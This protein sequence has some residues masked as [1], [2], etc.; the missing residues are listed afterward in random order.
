MFMK[1]VRQVATVV[2]VLIVALVGV[3]LTAIFLTSGRS[4]DDLKALNDARTSVIQL[5]GGIGLVGGLLF[6]WRTY[7]LSRGSQR[8]ERF[9]KAVGQLGES[10]ES[11]RAGGVYG[12]AK[13][14]QED[15]TYWPIIENLLSA[16][17]RERAKPNEQRTADLMA[18]LA[19]L[20]ARPVSSPVRVLDLR[21]ICVPKADLTNGNFEN[22]WFD[23]ASLHEADFTDGN[24]RGARMPKVILTKAKLHSADLRESTLVQADL[25]GSDLYFTKLKDADLDGAYTFG[26]LNL[27]PEQQS[28]IKGTLNADPAGPP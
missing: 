7:N 23:S 21:E 19:V 3:Q 13:L 4:S 20:G 5:A 17:L 28:A 18:A 1:S 2:G 22:A 16:H 24:F 9:T 14:G 6:T 12:L 11:V 27:T 25:R 8:A 26:V 15:E 10:S